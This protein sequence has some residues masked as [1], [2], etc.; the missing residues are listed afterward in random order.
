MVARQPMAMQDIDVLESRPGHEERLDGACAAAGTLSGNDSP[1]GTRPLEISTPKSVPRLATSMSDGRLSLRGRLLLLALLPAIVCSL[2]LWQLARLGAS[3][4]VYLLATL[5]TMGL[6]AAYAL[7]ETRR[8][9][10][11]IRTIINQSDNLSTS[12][13]GQ[14][15]GRS[16]SEVFALAK[17]FDAM[18]AALLTHADSSRQMYI[19]EAQNAL[20]LQRQ[21]ALMQMLRNLASTANNGETLESSLQN[22]LREI[23]SYLDWPIGRLV[24]V[25]RKKGGEIESVR[26][27]WY[28][29]DAKRYS[30]F[31]DACN[32]S[33]SDSESTGLIGRALESHLSHWVSD[34]GRMN[35]WSRREAALACGLRTG[36]VIPINAGSD[37]TAY[38]E[39]Y[40]DHRI[41][42]GAEMLELVE[43]ISVELW[44][45]ANRYQAGPSLHSPSARARRLAAV[46]ESMEEAIALAGADGRI[47]WAN[48]GLTR[49]VGFGAAQLIGKNLT[50][51]LFAAGSAS[52][53][54]CKRHLESGSR[55]VGVVLAAQT[56]TSEARWYELEIQ[57]L[58]DGDGSEPAETMF[59]VIRDVTHQ[60]AAQNALREAL[61]GARREN[62]S[63]AQFPDDLSQGLRAPMNQVLGIAELL[64]ASELDERQ[65]GLVNSLRRSTQAH[66]SIVNDMLDLSRLESGQM[67]LELQDFDPKA[68]IENLLG[69]VAPLAHTKGIE[70]VCKLSPKL[71]A[72]L[73][74]D[75]G[76]LRQI[77]SKLLENALKF[78]EHGEV[79]ITVEALAEPSQSRLAA[80]AIPIRIE[81]RDTG[82]GMRPQTLEQIFAAP[83]ASDFATPPRPAGTG[84]GLR[85][86]RRLAELMGGSI[87]VSS[88]IGEGSTF[89]LEVPL[90]LGD[91]SAAARPIDGSGSLAGRRVLIAEDNL[92]NRRVLCEQ[93]T[94]LAMDC[95]LA[96]N[97]RQALQML[98]IAASS[99]S[100][101]DFAVIDMRMPFM[102]GTELTAKIRSDPSLRS[103]RVIMLT[104]LA[105]CS[106]AGH[107]PSAG[108]DAYL[109][110]PVRHPELVAALLAAMGAAPSR[111]SGSGSAAAAP[112]LA[113]VALPVLDTGRR[114]E[115]G[116]GTIVTVA[117]APKVLEK[118]VLDEILLMERNGD[119]DLLRRLVQTYENCSQSLVQATDLSLANRDSVG[120]V[121][122]QHNLK[123][124]SANLGALG[125]SR[126]CA[127]VEALARQQR[128]A[129]AQ[130]RWSAV[131]AEHESVL[132]ALQALLADAVAAGADL[133]EA[134]R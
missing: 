36:F 110:K 43:A 124:S 4:S 132:L 18:T 96:E 133:Q 125:F 66:L 35:D 31:V 77:L 17:S 130:L 86:C 114:T 111:C 97:G 5:L 90:A 75:P 99:A 121:Q 113:P 20:D 93:L 98:R 76:R 16:H 44:N 1:L 131:R 56:E 68:L 55:A 106:D 12:Y 61:A 30:K 27:H 48:G 108:V 95:A 109:L 83:I 24:L 117:C 126:A 88:R 50:Q 21:Y 33:A 47:E 119:T 26:S 29:P 81:V 78:T 40:A 85:L 59:V 9:V 116:D 69:R 60:Q 67:K 25:T 115:L 2:T 89:Y 7:L 49:L 103:L 74:G 80:S 134:Q 37:T 34:L 13:C 19:A 107:A 118:R 120:V 129:D 41:E 15:P 38:V 11:P 70:L 6:C 42:A 46:A 54:E 101:F 112:A 128:L 52:A 94:A 104:S 100:P 63:R 127:E 102:D 91:C 53:A 92:T 71:P 10:R 72:M 84:L 65:R 23:G 79:A 73:F 39:F 28:A 82:A 3:W 51:L 57:P 122:A 22:S 58:P 45:T 87:G 62:P 123:L 105:N 32:E 8:L 14:L 64:L